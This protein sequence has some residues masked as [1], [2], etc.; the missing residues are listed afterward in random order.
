MAS[1]L[2]GVL[3]ELTDMQRRAVEWEDGAL[4]VV[5]GP[6]AGKTG[7]LACRAARL[8]ETSPDERF[9]VLG[10][11]F[12][13]KAAH[14]MKTRIAGLAPRGWERA[15]IHTFHGFAAQM[16]RQHGVHC[17]VSS[18]FEIYSRTADR[19]A[20]VTEALRRRADFDGDGKELLPRI[21]SLKARLVR[22]R[23]ARTHLRT[24]CNLDSDVVDR[25]QIAYE[26]YEEELKRANA[27]DFNSLILLAC[28]LLDQPVLARHY[29]TIYRYW[30]I[31]EFQDTTGAQYEL[32]R[33]MAGREFRQVLAVADDDQTIY[34]WNG[35]HV[36]RIRDLVRDFGCEVIQLT[37]NFRCPPIV[38]AA[39]NRLVVYNVRR[40]RG[41]APAEAVGLRSGDDQGI[42]RRVFT[43][44]G[45]E[46]SRIARE[47]ADLAPGDRA[48]TAILAR[49]RALLHPVQRELE[50]LGLPVRVLGRRDD[51]A[52]PR[53]RWLVAFL[54]QVHRPLDRRNMAKLMEAFGGVA[55]VS[56]ELDDI[57]ERSEADQVTPLAAW[58]DAVRSS[59]VSE[60]SVVDV[61]ARL[62]SETTSWMEVVAEVMERFEGEGADGD[63]EDDRVAWRRIEGEIRQAGGAVRLDRFLQEMELRSKEPGRAPDAVSLTTVHGAKGLEF[64]RVYLIGLAEEIFPSWHSVR[65]GN[66]STAIEEERRSCFVAITRTRR[67]LVLSRAEQYRG[68][69]KA[70]SRFLRE[71]GWPDAAPGSG[72]GAGV[73]S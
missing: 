73:F 46:A 16:L 67:K 61:A 24:H 8:I 4:L 2:V 60:R 35:A 45:E 41:R 32:L 5:A 6:G 57:I 38:V 31:D 42:E 11:T 30:L 65:Q 21:D 48:G 58:L 28:D 27:L 12:T 36:R 51:F 29:Q 19:Q 72:S 50:H 1:P 62:M 17:G 26:A 14:E 64:D 52:S 20:V 59:G 63:F 66:G 34:E 54:K 69:P 47:V 71:M 33:R 55:D 37:E 40:D 68:R 39:A 3:D 44:D 10:L 56:M 7:V 15:G 18:D 9:R 13:N 23:E 49:S 43:N 70:P 22:P 25:I 53:M